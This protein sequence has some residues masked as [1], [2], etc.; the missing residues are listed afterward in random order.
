MDVVSTGSHANNGRFS[1][2]H[3]EG[4]RKGERDQEE[5]GSAS[6]VRGVLNCVLVLHAISPWNGIQ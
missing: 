4:G 6:H 1:G 5:R 3:A 2:S